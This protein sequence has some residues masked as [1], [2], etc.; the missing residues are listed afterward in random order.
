MAYTSRNPAASRVPL[1]RD[2]VLDAALSIADRDGI[3]A[4]TMRRLA[5]QLGVEAMTIYYH[6]PN[7]EQ[8]I[9]GIVARVLGEIELPEPG[10]PWKPAIRRMALSARDTLGRHPWATARMMSG[11]LTAERLRYMESI[12]G[13]FRA[14]GFTSY[15]THLAYHAI[16]SHIVG[17]TLWL[18]GMNLPDDLS[19]LV[20]DVLQEVP[21]DEYP[22]F[23]EH[24]GEHLREARDTDVGTFEFGLDLI[25]DGLER[26]RSEA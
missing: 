26:M 15:Q 19:A 25:L 3:E 14:G 21:A 10:E 6:V 11:G 22:A 18:A 12:L 20:A 5:Q 16:E 13:C 24:L 2:R 9:D 8:I 23:V 1:S 17:F 4:L 7:K